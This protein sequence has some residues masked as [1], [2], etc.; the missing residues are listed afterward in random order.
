MSEEKSRNVLGQPLVPCS[1]EPLTGYRRDGCCDECSADTGRHL[2]CARMTD[3]FLEF[4]RERG[5]DLTTPAPGFPGLQPG[6]TWCLCTHRW[7]EALD[8]EV[9]PPVL[10][11]STAAGALEDLRFEDLRMHALDEHLAIAHAHRRN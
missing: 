9:A 10:L 4:A 7:Q 5:N 1:F 2:V 6:D 11:A 8:A 3:R